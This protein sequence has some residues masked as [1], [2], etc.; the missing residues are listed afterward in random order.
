MRIVNSAHQDRSDWGFYNIRF[1][2]PA[3]FPLMQSCRLETHKQAKFAQNDRNGGDLEIQQ[4]HESTC[5]SFVHLGVLEFVQVPVQ[6]TKIVVDLMRILEKRQ[7]FC[8][9]AKANVFGAYEH[10]KTNC[11]CSCIDYTVKN[12][13][14]IF[15]CQDA[16]RLLACTSKS[17]LSP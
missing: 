4:L 15:P 7:R 14:Q 12:T 9:P 16:G 1:E 2:A 5:F 6:I 13:S 17:L 3:T 11:I 8:V 10:M